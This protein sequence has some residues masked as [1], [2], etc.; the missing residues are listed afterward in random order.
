MEAI[1]IIIGILSAVF[2][3][4]VGYSVI[5]VVRLT[6]EAKEINEGLMGLNIN[7]KTSEDELNR[8]IDTDIQYFENKFNELESTISE[9]E[10]E[11]LS[12][13]DKRLD[14]LEN[15]ITSKIPPTNDEVLKELEQVRRDFLTLRQN[16]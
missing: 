7:I 13:L 2:T 12:L 1:Y 11:I 3:F 5:G 4:S 10:R 14:K 15:R 16:L 8:R 9:T 6:K